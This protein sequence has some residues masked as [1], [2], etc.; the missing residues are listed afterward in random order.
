M[1]KYNKASPYYTTTSFGK[2]LDL[3]N[4]R[5]ISKKADDLVFTVDQTYQFRPDRLAFDLYGDSALWWVFKARNPNAIEDPIFDFR[6]G[7]RIYIPKKG[8][9]ESELGI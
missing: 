8:T 2:F 9:L 1:A 4:Y 5:R 3:L 6:S 7:L